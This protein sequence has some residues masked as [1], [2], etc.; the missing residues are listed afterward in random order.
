MNISVWFETFIV[1][2]RGI[3]TSKSART[4]LR[5]RA[6]YFGCAMFNDKYWKSLIL[7]II[8]KLL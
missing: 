6:L 5:S 3:A 4:M 7:K 1:V 8:R 2:L